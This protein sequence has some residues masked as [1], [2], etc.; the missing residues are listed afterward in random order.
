MKD[1]IVL[2]FIEFQKVQIRYV[3]W[4]EFIA[5]PNFKVPGMKPNKKVLMFETQEKY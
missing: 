5:H 4:A 3:W 1:D 2:V